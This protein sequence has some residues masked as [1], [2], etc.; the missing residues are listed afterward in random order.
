LASAAATTESSA[1][2]SATARD[3]I[4]LIEASPYDASNWLLHE[5]TM[6]NVKVDRTIFPNESR[7]MI[8]NTLDDI[9]KLAITIP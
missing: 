8:F 2:G 1:P 5:L 7:D 6:F 3:I 4:D 9:P